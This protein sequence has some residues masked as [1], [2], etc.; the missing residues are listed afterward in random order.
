MAPCAAR[1]YQRLASGSDFGTSSPR[2]YRSPNV[3]CACVIWLSAARR[4]QISASC[5]FAG[6]PS[7]RSNIIA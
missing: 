6:V 5:G 3:N 1:S 4:S 2:S 7:P